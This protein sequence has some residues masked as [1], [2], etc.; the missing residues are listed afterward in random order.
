[1]IDIVYNLLIVA[2][3]VVWMLKMQFQSFR[4]LSLWVKKHRI[5][6]MVVLW[7]MFSLYVAYYV[8]NFHYLAE[9]TDVDDAV[10]AAVVNM[11]NG[12][13]P[14][15]EPV[16]PRFNEMGHF[17]IIGG[18]DHKPTWSYG[19]YNYLPLDLI[20][21]AGSYKLL[22]FAG[23]PLW[24]VLA[25]VVFASIGLYLLRGVLKIDWRYYL[26][27]AGM[28]VLF[29][30]MTNTSLTLLLV[31]A[32]VRVREEP[33]AQKEHLSLVLFGLASLTKIFAIVP[34]AVLALYGMRSSISEKDWHRFGRVLA[35]LGVCAGIAT[36]LI[37]P[38]GAVSVMDSTTFV[39]SA[40][41]AS[42]GT[43]AVGGSL[44]GELIPGS[45][46]YTLV[47]MGCV[48]AALVLSFRFR[49]P[50]D[51]VLLVF[52]VLLLV[53]AKSSYSPLFLAW[54]FLTLRIRGLSMV[55]PTRRVMS[56]EPMSDGGIRLPIAKPE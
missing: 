3:V 15:R 46:F 35:S 8:S 30:S 37:V 19:P 52:V 41:S 29:M 42:G 39:Y 18:G 6:V 7:I 48:L 14:Y 45:G 36:A 34:F 53:L 44:L 4:A 12:T 2:L 43:M 26:P 1:M 23:L 33:F 54:L 50:V 40:G 47:S 22:G 31:C 17:S 5:A 27:A 56:R 38:F 49:W 9:M 20:V 55:S 51:R 24:F 11:L 16:V 32:A 25:N 10:D 13:N 28:V 21:Y